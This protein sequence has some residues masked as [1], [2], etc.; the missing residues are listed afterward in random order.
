MQGDERS[1]DSAGYGEIYNV[2]FDLWRFGSNALVGWRP[3]RLGIEVITV[4]KVRLFFADTANPRIFA[5]SR[6]MGGHTFDMVAQ[7]L[8]VQ[9]IEI[10]LD[11]AIGTEPGEAHPERVDEL[12]AAFAV[13]LTQHRA[14]LL[15]DIVGF[16]HRSPAEQA[17]QLATLEFAIN[18]AEEISRKRGL[19]VELARTTTGDGFYVWNRLKGFTEDIDF[20]CC[21]ALF[22]MMF[23]TLERTTRVPAAIPELRLCLGIGSHF[24]YGQPRANGGMAGEFIVGNVTIE[25]ARLIGA[26]KAGQILVGD[27]RRPI[28]DGGTLCGTE[29]FLAAVSERING[30]GELRLLNMPVERLA[31]YLTGQR[32]ADGSYPPQAITVLDKHG[33]EHRCFNAKLNAHPVGAEPIFGGLQHTDMIQ[34]PD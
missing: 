5:G 22:V 19:K 30:L 32:A 16:S 28:S 15:I 34:A 9:P 20:F 6:Q 27:F 21:F 13:T 2:L 3:S 25:V 23:K 10:R 33:F 24:Q 31:F 14:V 29:V 11:Q 1:G 26:A 17:A 8:N 12:F 18:L 4:P 7:E